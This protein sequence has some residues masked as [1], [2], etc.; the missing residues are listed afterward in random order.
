MRFQEFDIV[1]ILKEGSDG[2]KEGEIGVILL[3]FDDPQEAYE[4][5]VLDE[6]GVVKVQR[7]FLPEE[8]ELAADFMTEQN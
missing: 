4:V 8:I 3:V 6:R 5:E 2:I 7:V 1:R